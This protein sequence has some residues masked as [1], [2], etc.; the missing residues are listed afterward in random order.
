MEDLSDVTSSGAPTSGFTLAEGVYLYAL[1][2]AVKESSPNRT[3]EEQDELSKRLTTLGNWLVNQENMP[4]PVLE[5]EQM[6]EMQ[7]IMFAA[8]C[9]TSTWI[10]PLTGA[11]NQDGFAESLQVNLEEDKGP[12]QL[13]FVDLDN[14][15]QVNDIHGHEA[16]DAVLKAF[17]EILWGNVRHHNR[18]NDSDS[19]FDGDDRRNTGTR[20]RE[21]ADNVIDITVSHSG[22]NPSI[23]EYFGRKGG[24]EFVLVAQTDKKGAEAMIERLS[25]F[26]VVYDAT[27]K[28]T[29]VYKYDENGK[30]D[31]GERHDHANLPRTSMSVGGS[32]IESYDA[33]GIKRAMDNA[34]K[35]M[36]KAK[37]ERKKERK[38]KK[39]IG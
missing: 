13:L 27:D 19:E 17:A 3:Q 6:V 5:P 36:Y 34:D 37:K 9:L 32:Q 10:D 30:V 39:L 8:S 7:T 11:L 24:D 33:S 18:R 35:S 20:R 38:S 22:G 26:F 31:F 29:Y 25:A 12:Y 4:K 1:Q 21:G 14:F 16:G 2:R 15:K 28:Q 23:D